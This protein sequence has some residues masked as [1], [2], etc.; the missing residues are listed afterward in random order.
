MD[1]PIFAIFSLVILIF[2]AVIHEVSHGYMADYL[3]DPTAKMQGRLTLNPI[4]HLDPMGSVVIP[5]LMFFAQ[6]PFIFGYAKPVPYNPRM[7]S[8]K[9]WG[10]TWVAA[11][12]PG[13]NIA[14]AL[15][16]SGVYQLLPVFISQQT[17]APLEPLFT[18]AIGINIMLAL[19]NLI[20][21]PPLDGSKILLPFLPYS[22]QSTIRQTAFGPYR[23]MFML[24][25]L[26]FIL[27]IISRI[28]LFCINLLMM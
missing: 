9:K 1:D 22:W 6:I 25:F 18:I 5:A 17:T 10:D 23:L 21:V 12:G 2:S 4:P 24:L 13:S 27:P 19:I 15:L 26:F 3:G 28:V 11:A 16:L 8:N 7:L 20:P 14:L